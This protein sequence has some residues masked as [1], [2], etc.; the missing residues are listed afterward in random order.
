MEDE[1]WLY[2]NETNTKLLPKFHFILASTFIN[3]NSKYDD[4]LNDL[5]RSIGKIS[6]DGDAWVDEHSGELICYNHYVHM[7]YT[8]YILITMENEKR[9]F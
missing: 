6:D 9:R 5:K 7:M 1:W 2:C 8:S 3:N 4:V